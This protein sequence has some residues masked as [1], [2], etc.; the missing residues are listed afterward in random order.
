MDQGGFFWLR[1]GSFWLLEKVVKAGDFYECIMFIWFRLAETLSTHPPPEHS[2]ELSP[3]RNLTFRMGRG[4]GGGRRLSSI[5]IG[6]AA[7]HVTAGAGTGG[8][9]A[10]HYGNQGSL[11]GVG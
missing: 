10:G 9:R 3:F 2:R 11:I 4:E 5:L 8:V 6:P 7:G 1:Y